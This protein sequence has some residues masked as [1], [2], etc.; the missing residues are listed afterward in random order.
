MMFSWAA[1]RADGRGD[2]HR[3]HN[4]GEQHRDLVRRDQ[5]GAFPTPPESLAK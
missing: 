2:V 5:V 3:M 4:I 1:L